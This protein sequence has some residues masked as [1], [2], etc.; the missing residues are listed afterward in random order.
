MK[1]PLLA[2]SLLSLCALTRIH[3]GEAEV[4]TWTNS[5]GQTIQASLV[6]V[7]AESG[8][9]TIR[10][11]DGNEFTVALSSFSGQDAKY[12][13][14]WLAMQTAPK[15]ESEALMATTGKLLF[16]DSFA[17][18]GEGWQAN[19]GDWKAEEGVL[20]GTEREADDHAGVMKRAMP[21][22][23]VVIEFGL[24]MGDAT[25]MSF[26]IDA[27]GHLCRLTV[28]PTSFQAKKD[29]MDKEGPNEGKAFN[30]VTTKLDTDE[31]QT[32]RMELLGQEMV[33]SI[34]D[35]VSMGTH[36]ELAMEKA[37]WGFT[38]SGGPVY[39]K[40]LKVWEAVPNEGWEST[41]KRLKRKLGIDD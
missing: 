18:I 13:E 35:D 32:V 7:S 26:S 3:A 36:E 23:D 21:L 27:D 29:D 15:P 20:I 19:V 40:D 16:S 17:S 37:K 33:T 10:R 11:E 22:K 12:V 39:I 4:R 5:A 28:S 38:V 9:V 2:V 31:W 1:A 25:G 41:S 30:T 14:N 34:G 6:S 24:K 8:E